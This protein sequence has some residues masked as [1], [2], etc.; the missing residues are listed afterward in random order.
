MRRDSG[1]HVLCEKPIAVSVA[2][3]DSMI[4]VCRAS[5]VL[6]GVVFQQR[7]AFAPHHEAP[8]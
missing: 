2:E 6:L 5:G 1:I 8:D 4:E 7:R 3:A